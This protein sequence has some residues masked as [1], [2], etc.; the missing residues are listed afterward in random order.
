MPGRQWLHSQN[1]RGDIEEFYTTRPKVQLVPIVN[2]FKSL[3]VRYKLKV[4]IVVSSGNINFSGSFYDLTDTS[5]DQGH[6]E[7]LCL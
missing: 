1:V 7:E 5:T 4:F 3:N 6:S 2:D